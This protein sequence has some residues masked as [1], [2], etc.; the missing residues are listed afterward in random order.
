MKKSKRY[1]LCL[2]IGS[3]KMTSVV[4]SIDDHDIVDVIGFGMSKSGG[5]RDGRVM[6]IDQAVAALQRSVDEAEAMTDVKV[7]PVYLSTSGDY[8]TS[9]KVSG[10]ISPNDVIVSPKDVERAIASAEAVLTP[11]EKERGVCLIDI[12]GTSDAV[13]F[14]KGRIR[15]TFGLLEGGQSFTRDLAERFGLSESWAETLKIKH[16]CCHA[17]RLGEAAIVEGP[18]VGGGLARI[19]SDEICAVLSES[20]KSLMGDV[21]QRLVQARLDHIIRD[22]VITGGSTL[23][24]GMIDLAKEVFDRPARIGA[25]NFRADMSSWA[26]DPRFST[27]VGLAH[28]CF[29]G[30]LELKANPD[31][32]S[33]PGGVMGFF[34]KLFGRKKSRAVSEFRGVAA[35]SQTSAV[36]A[37]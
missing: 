37:Q 29:R 13:F 15:Q 33:K 35:A 24:P 25:P 10:P 9:V 31:D 11:D 8:I 32:D 16:G 3:T 34:G 1:M 4:I 5:M 2:D 18:Q 12:G 20:V 17:R 21:C 22:V 23:M 30:A 26:N 14:S 36:S 7:G 6:D 27:A 28:L 19:G